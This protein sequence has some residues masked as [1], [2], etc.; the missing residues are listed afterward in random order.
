MSQPSSARLREIVQLA[1]RA[2]SVHNTQPWRWRILG[3]TTLDLYA[4]RRRQLPVA[5]P[6]GRNLALSCGAALHHVVEVAHI[7]GLEAAVDLLPV[8]TNQDFLARIRLTPGRTSTDAAGRLRAIEDRRTDRRRFTSWPVP[9]ARLHRLAEGASGWG[10]YV[11]PITDVTARFRAELLIDE[12]LT[13]QAADPRYA[14]E[15]ASWVQRSHADGVP[16]SSASPSRPA[17]RAGHPHRFASRPESSSSQ[18]TVESSDGLVSLCT[19]HDD[20]RS[21]LLAGQ[22]LSALWLHATSSGLS[23]VPLSQVIELPKTR[24]LLRRDVFADMARP[25]LLLRV[26]WQEISR[27]SLPRTPRRS[28]QD[29]LID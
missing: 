8:A 14:A 13:I 26:G 5:D 20:E 23:I 17:S 6:Q 19:G 11:V 25:Q 24:E 22:A 15:Q 9:E 21:W 28:L 10:A 1:G 7:M 2:P 3:D 18:R 12:A 16:L 29:V 4:D 27:A